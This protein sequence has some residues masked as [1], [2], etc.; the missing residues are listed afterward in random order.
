ML[1]DRDGDGTISCDEFKAMWMRLGRA[2]RSRE[3]K[4]RTTEA[5]SARAREDGRLKQH[6]RKHRPER[7]QVAESFAPKDVETA[8]KKIYRVAQVRR[9]TSCAIMTP[10]R[11]RG[12]WR[13]A[14]RN[15]MIAPR[16]VAPLVTRPLESL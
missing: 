11:S 16:L 7:H 2:Q 13:G 1:F 4:R 8:L 5:R 12:R 3:R 10:L 15:F 9:L 14:Y 6:L